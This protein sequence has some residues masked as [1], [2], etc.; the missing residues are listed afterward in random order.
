MVKPLPCPMCGAE[1]RE[2]NHL[3]SNLFEV[4]CDKDHKEWGVFSVL[5]MDDAIE[6]WNV[7]VE[8][9]KGERKL[10]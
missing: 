5:N 10:L 4:I 3:P 8:I 6:F 9:E 7:E 1:P 2:R